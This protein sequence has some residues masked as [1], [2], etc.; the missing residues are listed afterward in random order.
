MGWLYRDKGGGQICGRGAWGI[1]RGKNV[2]QKMSEENF[3]KKCIWHSAGFI[4][5]WGGKF[6]RRG[7]LGNFSLGKCLTGNVLGKYL[8]K[9]SDTQLALSGWVGNLWG[10]MPGKLFVGKNVRRE[11]SGENIWGKYLWHSAGFI[12]VWGGKFAAGVPG[13][14]FMGKNAWQEMS[15]ESIWEKYLTLNWLYRGGGG[16]LWGAWGI[17]CGGKS[18]AGNVTGDFPGNIW[19]TSGDVKITMQ[20]WRSP[21]A[22]V[23]I[24]ATLVN[25]QTDRHIV[26]EAFD[27]LYIISSA[28]RAKKQM[29]FWHLSVLLCS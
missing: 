12:G 29:F 19:G 14:F 27:W 8:G 22:A 24:S 9:I 17:V 5:M 28:S 15:W 20:D 13:E 7:C 4:G 18:T 6:L 16:D 25:R 1:V 2:R 23:M 10:G 26:R 3:W 11:M 21:R